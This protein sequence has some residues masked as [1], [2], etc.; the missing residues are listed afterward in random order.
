MSAGTAAVLQVA[1]LVGALALVHLVPLESVDGL[2]LAAMLAA[3][4]L[5]AAGGLVAFNRRD[6]GF[7]G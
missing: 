1:V 2:A 4:F 3:A 5:V 7:S 6:V